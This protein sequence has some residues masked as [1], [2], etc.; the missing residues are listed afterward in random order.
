MSFPDYPECI[1]FLTLC[2]INLNSVTTLTLRI[3]F[4][5]RQRG[6][7]GVGSEQ[8]YYMQADLGLNPNF[9]FCK[10]YITWTAGRS[11][12]PAYS[13]EGLMLKLKLQYFGHL[14]WRANTLE[15]APILGKIEGTRRRRWQRMKWLD[16]ITN[17]MDVNLSKLRET[18]MN[19]EA[20]CAAVRGVAKSWL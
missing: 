5:K 14:M 8:V 15:K 12:N 7:L 11:I 6:S 16:N 20:W 3:G 2:W 13:L 4:W 17:Y 10:M 9:V 1:F 19:R 18:V